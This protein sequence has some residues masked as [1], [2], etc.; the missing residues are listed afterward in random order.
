MIQWFQK[1]Q[2][3]IRG[4]SASAVMFMLADF[5]GDITDVK[6]WLGSGAHGTLTFNLRVNG[7][8]Q[9]FGVDVM[10]LAPGAQT[11]ERAGLSIAVTEGDILQI[12]L[13]SNTGGALISFPCRF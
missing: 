8:L 9:F 13:I 10:A 2:D 12:D 11:V 6:I 4:A 7:V 3:N 5:D 1:I